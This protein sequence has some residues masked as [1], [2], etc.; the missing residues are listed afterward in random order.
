MGR[1]EDAMGYARQ[2]VPLGLRRT[3][4]RSVA[5]RRQRPERLRRLV[6][7]YEVGALILDDDGRVP[8]R[9]WRKA[10]NFGDLLSPWLVSRMTGREVVW[11]EDRPHYLVIGSV[12]NGANARSM[13]WGAG[14][15]GVDHGLR[16]AEEATYA[17]VRGPQTRA[18]LEARGIACPEVYGDPALL[19][20][21]F[22]SPRVEK[23]YEYGIL[24]RWSERRW[25]DAEI[26]PGVRLI[27]LG[28]ADVETV[29]EELL[30]CRR[31]L[32]GSLHGLV[33]ADAYGIPNAWVR[34][35]SAFGGPYKFFDYFATVG[36]FRMYQDFDMSVPVTA[37]RLRES[38][39]F[40]GRPISFDYRALLDA[41]PFLE[42]VDLDATVS[43]EP[44]R[45]VSIGG[46][47]PAGVSGVRGTLVTRDLRD[48][49]PGPR[50][51]RETDA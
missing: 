33:I 5:A 12:L 3:L 11:A 49:L 15:F 18:R 28:S 17:A 34:T 51:L 47:E 39:V 6:A 19:A 42:R 38:L 41:C 23:K 32:S 40:D 36:K 27:D 2:L 7:E 25:N 22:Y 4:R 24:V 13:V 43:P 14:S 10:D 9:W 35:P 45:S 48:P 21:A 29:I 30:S 37:K 20:P 31:V 8:V 50:R 1:E 16:S 26:G 44:D 46:T